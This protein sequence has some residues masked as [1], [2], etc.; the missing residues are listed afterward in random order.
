LII[1]SIRNPLTPPQ[2]PLLPISPLGCGTATYYCRIANRNSPRRACCN[3][4]NLYVLTVAASVLPPYKFSTGYCFPIGSQTITTGKLLSFTTITT[5]EDACSNVVFSLINP[6]RGASIN[7][8]SRIFQLDSSPGQEHSHFVVGAADGL[9]RSIVIE[10]N[11][12][13]R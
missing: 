2:R 7:P 8:T 12:R 5:D 1:M 13:S 11:N 10:G 4:S 6:P 9:L 3:Q